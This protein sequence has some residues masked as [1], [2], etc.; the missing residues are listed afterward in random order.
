MNVS[1]L[2]DID[3]NLT[4]PGRGLQKFYS[5]QYKLM[6]SLQLAG[7]PP[8]TQVHRLYINVLLV[9]IYSPAELIHVSTR[10]REPGHSL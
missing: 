5:T 3:N 2:F 10:H 9:N 1:L 6:A 8:P 7:P 4:S